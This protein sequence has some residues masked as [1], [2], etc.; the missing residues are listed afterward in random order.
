MTF[1]RIKGLTK[2]RFN[3]E[4]IT[5]NVNKDRKKPLALS[6]KL[7]VF[8]DISYVCLTNYTSWGSTNC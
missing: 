4:R 7:T 3:K 5:G 1:V 2:I 6:H 8:Y